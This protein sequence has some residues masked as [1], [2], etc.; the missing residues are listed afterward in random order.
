MR[1]ERKEL[2][3]RLAPKYGISRENAGY[4]Y[5]RDQRREAEAGIR[6]TLPI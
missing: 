4:P 2:V 6:L 3:L 5:R 1:L